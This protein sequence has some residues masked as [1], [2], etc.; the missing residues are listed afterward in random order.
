MS[1]GAWENA[2]SAQKINIG[3]NGVPILKNVDFS[4]RRGEVHA[5]VGSNGAGKSTLMKILCG[6]YHP[7]GGAIRF[8][9][10]PID[11]TSPGVASKA[12]LEMVFQELSLI[13]TLTVAQNVFLKHHPYRRG[14]FID[15]RRANNEAAKLLEIV[16]VGTS[17]APTDIVEELSSGQRQVVEIV[18]ALASNPKIIILDE[19]TASLSVAEIEGVFK[20]IRNLKERDISVIYITH[21]LQDL[22]KICDR[23]TVLRDGE[24][25]MNCPIGET[26]LAKIVTA[27]VGDTR[28]VKKQK[29]EAQAFASAK[30]LL[31]VNNLSTKKVKNISFKVQQGE[32]VGIAGLLGSGRSELFDAL[33]GIDHLHGG[34]ILVNGKQLQLHNSSAAI[35]AGVALVPENRRTRGL[36]VDFS[37]T[38]NI[39]LSILDRLT[40]RFLLNK[41]AMSEHVG[42]MIKNLDIKTQGGNQKVR[43][44][45]GGNQQKI[46][47]AK[48]LSTKSR[49][50]LLDDPTFGVDIHAKGEIMAIIK[51]FVSRGNGAI[52]VSSEFNEIIE[53]CDT[54]YIMKQGKISTRLDNSITE[55][56]LLYQVQ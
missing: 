1:E 31:E 14:P 6:V 38:E 17:T 46:V 12:G 19:P 55:D 42:G 28:K 11:L 10:N 3:F 48:C 35:D 54:I 47:V 56:Q 43:F 50:L 4:L 27:M 25:A 5:V 53:F 22:F 7:Q 39:I 2:I 15:D 13:P 24:V 45:S 26:S 51:E 18:K 37:V 44:L 41:A 20:V 33:Y 52:F 49:L 32:I 8:F 34:E 21:Y 29:K 23:V 9:N 16:G 40:K 30:T 36:I